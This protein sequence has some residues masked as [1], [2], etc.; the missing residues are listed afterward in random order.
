M[1]LPS[2]RRPIARLHVRG[3]ATP[4]D[5]FV[6]CLNGMVAP[7][8]AVEHLQPLGSS[9]PAQRFTIAD[10]QGLVTYVDYPL[11]I[12][13][14]ERFHLLLYRG[15]KMAARDR[16]TPDEARRLE[17]DAA[18]VQVTVKVHPG[19]RFDLVAGTYT[20]AHSRTG[21]HRA[22][23]AGRKNHNKAARKAPTALHKNNKKRR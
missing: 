7:V 3:R 14:A 2:C 17:P 10:R 21:H 12:S 19:D 5:F 16:I 6:Q 18:R 20:P 22:P 15:R 1:N 11:A 9:V 8:G 4:L 13:L 23:T